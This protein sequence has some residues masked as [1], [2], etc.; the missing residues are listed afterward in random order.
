MAKK[1]IM[2]A[3]SGGIDS[4]V[5]AFLLKEKFDVKGIHF[6]TGY[7][8]DSRKHI[9]SKIIEMCDQINISADFLDISDFF[10]KNIVRYFTKSY[11]T[12]QTPNPCLKCNSLVK[13]GLLQD[14]AEKTGFEKIATGHY[15]RTSKD[16]EGNIFILKG[17]DK[18]K[19]Q[20][21]FLSM[22]K[23][24]HLAKTIF[25]L[26]ELEKENI[27][28]IAEQNN[29]IPVEKK[30]SQDICFIK[31]K[32]YSQFLKKNRS[33]K[34]KQGKIF[35]SSGKEIGSHNG[36]QNFTIGQRKGINCPGPQAYYV[37]GIYPDENKIIVGPKNELFTDKL[38]IG[39]MNWFK[40]PK[41]FPY[42]AEI[43]IRYSHLPQKASIIKISD[44]E[45]MGRFQDP[46]SSVTPGQGAV[47]YEQD[48]I[49]GAGF[50][51][52]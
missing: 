40:Y 43:K 34:L 10:E 14:Y 29:L 24:E 15:V 37:L 49:T 6:F 48:I 47:I 44:N 33:F 50:I 16:E 2:A 42:F 1:K 36:I 13:F 35:N 52:K 20:S 8:Q 26:G 23:Q 31:N 4:L 46:V 17:K 27:F 3:I 28:K 30:E 22:V 51:L 18:K 32:K 12:G 9:K 5:A 19:D 39:N 38:F 7:E 25:P 45:Y 11:L 21:Y 41:K